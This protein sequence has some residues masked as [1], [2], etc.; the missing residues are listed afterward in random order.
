[1]TITYNATGINVKIFEPYY[2]SDTKT[3]CVEIGQSNF[4]SRRKRKRKSRR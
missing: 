2:P 3:R 1:M 4:G